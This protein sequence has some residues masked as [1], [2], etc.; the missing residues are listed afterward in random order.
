MSWDGNKSLFLHAVEE[1]IATAANVDRNLTH[2]NL[3]TTVDDLESRKRFRTESSHVVDNQDQLGWLNRSRLSAELD[4]L[5][6]KP[7]NQFST[8]CVNFH[9]IHIIHCFIYFIILLI[10]K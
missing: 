5:K 4:E 6:I 7:N 10:Y 8:N 2:G 1:G 9:H 3:L